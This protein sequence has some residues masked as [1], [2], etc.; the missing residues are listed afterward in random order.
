MPARPDPLPTSES[1]LWTDRRVSSAILPTMQSVGALM[2]I[3]FRGDPR[4]KTIECG[5]ATGGAR[6]EPRSGTH[7]NGPT[8]GGYST[9]PSTAGFP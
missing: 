6:G 3:L 7:T 5:G 2:P 9:P 1:V 8:A 4:K